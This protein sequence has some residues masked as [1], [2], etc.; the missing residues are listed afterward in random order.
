MIGKK[1]DV[2]SVFIFYLSPEITG[3]SLWSKVSVAKTHSAMVRFK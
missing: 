1:L 2:K 3:V